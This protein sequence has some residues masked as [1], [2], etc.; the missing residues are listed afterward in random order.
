MNWRMHLMQNTNS[1]KTDYYGRGK[2]K[3][4]TI[5][6]NFPDTIKWLAVCILSIV[7]AIDQH[8]IPN[9]DRAR[10]KSSCLWFPIV[11]VWIYVCVYIFRNFYS[12][13]YIFAENNVDTSASYVGSL[14]VSWYV[15]CVL[16]QYDHI[17]FY[18]FTMQNQCKTSNI[19]D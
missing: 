15:R 5:K 11:R 2:L 8:K 4:T 10:L 1:L 9:K 19:P 16:S 14:Y 13:I 3:T 7:Q 18:L 17:L 6:S 12:I